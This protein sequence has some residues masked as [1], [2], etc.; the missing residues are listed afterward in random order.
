MNEDKAKKA[1]EDK[2]LVVGID[3]KFDS[4]VE[5]SKVISTDPVTGTEVDQGTKVTIYVS[6]GSEKVKVPSVVGKSS[7]DAQS[8]I[9]GEGLKV[10]VTEEYS[11]TVTEGYVI[12]QSKEGGT[13]VETG[14][15]INIVVSLGPKEVKVPV[16]QLLGK[17]ESEAEK[18]LITA[19]LGVNIVE[20]YD[21]SV[22]VGYV[23]SQSVPGGSQVAQGTTVTIV[24][25]LGPEQTE[26]E[27]EPDDSEITTE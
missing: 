20:Q 25:S 11:D 26:A 12:S 8:A 16:P 9:I 10:S 23:I 17:S 5:E 21:A 19:G 1:L 27:T 13:K 4:N 18:E 15:T 3:Y 6:K 22:T 7:S 24:V 14:T 2:G